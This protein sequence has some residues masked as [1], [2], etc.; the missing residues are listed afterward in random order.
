MQYLSHKTPKAFSNRKVSVAQAIKMLK[1]NDITTKEDE[2]ETILDF[3]YFIAK[4]YSND[5]NLNSQNT[6]QP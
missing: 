1:R 4:T 3:L 5:Q 6:Q 2:A